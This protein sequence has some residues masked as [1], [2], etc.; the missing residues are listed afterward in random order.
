MDKFIK[1]LQTRASRKGISVSKSQVREV[2]TQVVTAPECPSEEDMISVIERL[3]EQF[4]APAQEPE[5]N[6]ITV[7]E[8]TESIQQSAQIQQQEEPQEMTPAQ[9]VQHSETA[10]MPYQSN[11]MSH[12]PSGELGVT[13]KQIKEAVELQFGSQSQQTKEAL[14]SYAFQR[15]FKNADDLR[16]ALEK[17]A[18]LEQ[19]AFLKI[20]ADFN[21]TAIANRDMYKSALEEVQAKLQREDEDFFGSLESRLAGMRAKFGI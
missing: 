14:V 17:I 7:S 6:Q 12:A 2:Y 18:Q 5:S 21:T 4:K 20:I 3:E 10:M 8:S 1:R 15:S 11:G 13:G 9:P 16:L 19:D